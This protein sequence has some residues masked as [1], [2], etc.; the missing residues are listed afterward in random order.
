[1]CVNDM[2]AV[3][4]RL[5]SISELIDQSEFEKLFKTGKPFRIIRA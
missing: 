4:V 1:M 5:D 2:S 3:F